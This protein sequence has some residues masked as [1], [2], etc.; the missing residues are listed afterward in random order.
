M[1]LQLKKGS[2]SVDHCEGIVDS[3]L[4]KGEKAP[5]ERLRK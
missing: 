2:V 3:S 5:A 1:P 4:A